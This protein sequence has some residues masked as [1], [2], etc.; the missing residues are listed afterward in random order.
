MKRFVFKLETLLRVKKTEEATAQKNLAEAQM[1]LKEY[2]EQ[3]SKLVNERLELEES[4][5]SNQ[6]FILSTEELSANFA[7][8]LQLQKWIAQQEDA[9][10]H[11]ENIVA[12]KRQELVEAMKSKK[13]IESLKEKQYLEW[14]KDIEEKER[15]FLDELATIRYQPRQET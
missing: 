10:M 5:R 15:K 8:L 7:Y 2:Q 1:V 9:I 11:A 3:R 13:S 4:V 14:Q 6:K 12:Q